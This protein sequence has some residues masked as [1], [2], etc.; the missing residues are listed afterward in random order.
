MARAYADGLR[1]P[2][3]DGLRWTPRRIANYYLARLDEWQT[4][5]T[6]RAAPLQL[7]LEANNTCNLH[8]PG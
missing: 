2:H 8:C 1:L 6:V 4:R 3:Y 5:T 7:H